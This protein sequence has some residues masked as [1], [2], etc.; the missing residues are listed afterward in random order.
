MDKMNLL[1]TGANGFIGQ[2]FLSHYS[3]AYNIKKFSFL[4]DDF[5]ELDLE[6]IQT[7]V[8]LSA[9]VHQMGG[10]TEEEY[11]RINVDQT[12]NL[13]KKA[14]ESGVDSFIFMSTVK[15]YGEETEVAYT[16]ETTCSPQDAYGASK[17]KAEKMLLALEDD[18]FSI[19][20]IRTPIVYGYGVKAN[21]K[22]LMNL[23]NKVP[24]LPFGNI[25]NSRS[26]VY[27]GNLSHLIDTVIQHKKSGIYLASDDLSMSTSELIILISKEL[28]KN[29][30][31]IRVPFFETLLKVLKPSFHKRLYKSLEVD[32]TITKKVL[33][34]KN[35]YSNEEGIAYMLKGENNK[36]SK[37]E[38]KLYQ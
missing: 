34:Y 35:I 31:L 1:L 6:G 15:V 9:L 13:A 17:L 18:N 29:S 24:I 25:E 38:Q 36:A 33:N 30:F 11:N 23:V 14:K 22:N 12:I 20:I 37:I 21:I 4:N 3:D 16:E 2:Y 10:A 28:N 26:M 7:I 5:K 8:H 27:V 32:N 19:S